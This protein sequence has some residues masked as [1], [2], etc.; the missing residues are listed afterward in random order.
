MSFEW[1]FDAEG[2]RNVRQHVLKTARFS[3]PDRK[4]EIAF[5][6]SGASANHTN[7]KTNRDLRTIIRLSK[8]DTERKPFEKTTISFAQGLKR[9]ITRALEGS[10]MEFGGEGAAPLT[11]KENTFFACKS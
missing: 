6:G 9:R 10:R 5:R 4:G 11:L 7:H 8:S 3:R 1:A 2:T